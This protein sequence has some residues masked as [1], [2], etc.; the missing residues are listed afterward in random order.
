VIAWLESGNAAVP[1]V[2]QA[3]AASVNIKSPYNS[4]VNLGRVS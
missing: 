1:V 4:Q 3:L 2:E